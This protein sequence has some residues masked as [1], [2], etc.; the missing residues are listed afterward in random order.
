MYLVFHRLKFETN[1][2]DQT[3]YRDDWQLCETAEEARQAIAALQR[4]HGDTLSDWGIGTIMD[5]SEASWLNK[6]PMG[7]ED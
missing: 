7:L 6:Q 4:I 2:A 3:S 1:L 5:A